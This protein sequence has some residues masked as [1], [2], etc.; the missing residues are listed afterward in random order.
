[1]CVTPGPSDAAECPSCHKNLN[2]KKRYK[3]SASV[4]RSPFTLRDR[5]ICGS[6]RCQFHQQFHLPNARPMI[7]IIC[8]LRFSREE[9]FYNHVMFS[10]ERIFEYFCELCDRSFSTQLLLSRHAKLHGDSTPAAKPGKSA[11]E[12]SRADLTCRICDKTF[13]RVSRYHKHLTRHEQITSNDVLT[14][15]RCA[16]IFPNEDKANAHSAEVHPDEADAIGS[17]TLEYAL[18]CEFCES[19]FYDPDVLID[20]KTSHQGDEKPFE[21]QFCGSR[22]DAFSKLKTHNNSHA[23]LVVPFPVQ[24]NYMCDVVDCFKRYRHWSDL[25]CHQKTVHLINPTIY[26]CPECEAT[27]YN[28][29]QFDYH[30]KS[31][32]S[33]PSKCKLCDRMFQTLMQLKTHTRRAHKRP[34]GQPT[35]GG[36]RRKS[37]R[38]TV[39][40]SAHIRSEDD[41]LF[42]RDC[43]KFLPSRNNARSHI[44]MVHLKIK[45]FD[46]SVCGKAFYLRKDFEDHE[47]LHT[48]DTP[49]HCSQCSKQFRT[50]SLLTEHRK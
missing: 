14:C 13:K 10:H 8:E 3:L 41:K 47:R 44:E 21:C 31:V 42:C 16:L 24:R 45:N 23:K 26:K 48:A 22:Y 4:S 36:S 25:Q 34:A 7:C 50:S 37:K 11:G 39:D 38:S 17:R 49:F 5:N 12:H 35:V 29:W 20:H 32:H 46:C 2:S 43:G 33:K 27:F 18:C 28:S 30:K 9:W 15:E 6:F 40:I 19:A 1:M